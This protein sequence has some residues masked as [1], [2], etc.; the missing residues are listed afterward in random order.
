[1]HCSQPPS[2]DGCV[3]IV[4]YSCHPVLCWSLPTPASS[5][6]HPSQPVLLLSHSYACEVEFLSFHIRELTVFAFLCLVH[7]TQQSELRPVAASDRCA[8]E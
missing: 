3:D 2:P 8:W 1:M 5:A 4:S 7:F 6:C